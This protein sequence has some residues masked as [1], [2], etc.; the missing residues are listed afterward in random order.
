MVIRLTSPLSVASRCGCNMAPGLQG[1]QSVIPSVSESRLAAGLAS[2]AQAGEDRSRAFPEV[3]MALSPLPPAG[4]ALAIAGSVF[5]GLVPSGAHLAYEA[6]ASPAAFMLTRCLCVVILVGGYLFIRRR[7]VFPGRWR[8]SLGVGLMITSAGLF[9]M[10]SVR[11]LPVALASLLFFTFSDRHRSVNPPRPQAAGHPRPA[12]WH[13][14]C[15]DR[16][17]HGPR[18]LGDRPGPVRGFPGPAGRRLRR[19]AASFAARSWCRKPAPCRS[20]S[21]AGLPDC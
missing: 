7:P 12:W 10:A 19:P 15:F 11:F 20:T 8:R 18:R 13:P 21:R 17:R 3:S 6:G 16:S 5:L 9:Y 1:V 14:G 2:G 4:V